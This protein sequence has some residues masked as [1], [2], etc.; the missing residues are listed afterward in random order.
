MESKNV[1]CSD[2]EEYTY[3]W[4]MNH[5]CRGWFNVDLETCK[6]YCMENRLPNGCNPPMNAT[7]KYVVY[8]KIGSFGSCN[9]AQTCNRDARMGYS[10]FANKRGKSC[11]ILEVE[12]LET[13]DP[14]LTKVAFLNY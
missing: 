2:G 14:I 11:V 5:D 4:N 6:Q 8:Y 1:I 10:V 13:N 9:L 3:S 12:F 7:C